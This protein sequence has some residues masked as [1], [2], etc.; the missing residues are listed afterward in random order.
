MYH[1]IWPLPTPG[2]F[3]HSDGA[4][5]PPS[6]TPSFFPIFPSVIASCRSTLPP[7]VSWQPP[8]SFRSHPPMSSSVF[9]MTLALTA[10]PH[11]QQHHTDIATPITCRRFPPF[12]LFII[13]IPIF[14]SLYL[15]ITYLSLP[16]SMS[17]LKMRAL[18]FMTVAS[19]PYPKHAD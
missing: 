2:P 4:C 12:I 1:I 8:S 9:S 14:A 3:D 17:F 16:P 5:H 19:S 13:L 15:L 7:A 10:A 6:A 18:S 11:Q